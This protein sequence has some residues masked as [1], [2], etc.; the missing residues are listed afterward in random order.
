MSKSLTSYRAV[1]R[2]EHAHI[3]SNHL[4]YII[5]FIILASV[6]FAALSE[7]AADNPALM[8]LISQNEDARMSVRDLAFFLVTHD[9]DATPR[10]DY[11]EVYTGDTT[12]RLVPNGQYVGLANVTMTS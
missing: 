2:E 6:S 3:I 5:L 9:F 8:R 7:A 10:D 11:V 12:Y 1:S 4:S